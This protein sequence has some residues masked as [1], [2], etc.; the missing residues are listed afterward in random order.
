[1]REGSNFKQNLRI[2]QLR[3][4]S[5]CAAGKI[6]D[7]KREIKILVLSYIYCRAGGKLITETP[8]FLFFFVL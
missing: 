7:G 8:I 4:E 5:F 2:V 3:F 6:D 1:M